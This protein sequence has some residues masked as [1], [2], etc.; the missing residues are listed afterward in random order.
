[1]GSRD[2]AAR[3]RAAARRGLLHDVGHLPLSHT[4]EGIGALNHHTVGRTQIASAAVAEALALGG[5]VVAVAEVAVGTRPTLLRPDRGR[6]GLDHLDSFVRAG[7]VHGW[8]RMQPAAI[9]DALHVAEGALDGGPAVG[10]EPARLMVNN[11]RFHAH[12]LNVGP[13]ALVRRAFRRLVAAD[14]ETAG[15]L[16]AANDV[17]LWATLLSHDVSRDEVRQILAEPGSAVVTTGEPVSP[18]EPLVLAPHYV[19]EPVAELSAGA[20]QLLRSVDG[21]PTSFAVGWPHE[22]PKTARAMA[23]RLTL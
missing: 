23:V 14:P 5:L 3:G 22:V 10:D 20:R 1:V 11:A 4:L 13:T 6:L 8:L 7:R 9:L 12:P 2:A 18:L 17:E 16:T 21:L 15:R 19:Y